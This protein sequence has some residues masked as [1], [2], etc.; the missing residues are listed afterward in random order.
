MYRTGSLSKDDVLESTEVY[1]NSKKGDILSA[2]ALRKM[3]LEGDSIE[4]ILQKGDCPLTTNELRILKAQKRKEFINYIRA[5]FTDVHGSAYGES[6]IENLLKTKKINLDHRKPVGML[7]DNN[8]KKIENE[9]VLKRKP[10]IKQTVSI[11]YKDSGKFRNA[12]SRYIVDERYTSSTI[13]FDLDIPPADTDRYLPLISKFSSVETEESKSSVE[14][15]ES[16]G[17]PKSK[18]TRNVMN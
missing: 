18:K 8:R 17:K 14:T 12:I 15:E 6:L 9:I 7:F 3:N 2:D 11:A 16:N 10:G 4:Y 5:N 13:E 1:S